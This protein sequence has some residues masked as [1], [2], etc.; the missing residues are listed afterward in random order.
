MNTSVTELCLQSEC[1]GGLESRRSHK[2]GVGSGG[3]RWI[4]FFSFSNSD[5]MF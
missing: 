1:F 5:L 2:G 4:V 3:L